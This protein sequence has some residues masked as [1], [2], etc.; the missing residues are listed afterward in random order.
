MA[1]R[2]AHVDAVVGIARVADLLLVLLEPLVERAEVEADQLAPAPGGVLGGAPAGRERQ[3]LEL[4]LPGLGARA[5]G[6]REQV[7]PARPSA[8][9]SQTG[10][11]PDWC[12]SFTRR[13]STTVSPAK[14]PRTQ[15]GESST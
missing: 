8:G 7:G 15:R 12:T 2:A 1:R 14:R 4:P 3:Q 11:R 6:L 9:K 13:L 10:S 5:S